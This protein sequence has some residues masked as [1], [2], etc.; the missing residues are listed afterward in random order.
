MTDRKKQFSDEPAAAP[1]LSEN[2]YWEVITRRDPA[3]DGRFWYGVRT[4]GVYCRPSCASRQ[5]K[6]EN[7]EFFALP[8]AARQRGYRPCRRCRP[9]AVA[10]RDPQSE[11]VQRICRL[12]DAN[13]AENPDLA[14]LGRQVQVSPSHLQRVFK[15]L[16]GISPR[17][18]L[19]ARR[20]DRFKAGVKQ[21]RSVTEAMYDAGYGSSSRLYEKAAGQ[22]GM[23]PATYR[24]GGKGMNIGY[25]IA[26][27][28][29]GWLLVAATARGVCW[30]KLGDDREQLA[31]RLRDEFPRAEI[32]RD[33][34]HLHLQ[35]Q[36][37]LECLAGQ[38]PHT[39]LPL[40]VQGTAFQMRVWE[41]LRRIPRGQTV[42]Y[43]ELAAR[44]GRP[45][46]YRAVANACAG[47]PVSVLTPCHR[48]VR[49]DGGLGG[50]ACGVERK[51]V[52]LEKEREG[53]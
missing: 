7:V 45:R 53:K 22:L 8:D 13:V 14:F 5:P 6:R 29:L 24:K 49:E 28:P 36:V 10:A 48:V 39:D 46:A 38:A 21:G 2:E 33:D 11:L 26:E 34:E 32:R 18:Y 40:D 30:V 52:L 35:V 19:A 27:S 9:D 50:Y 17:R 44:I 41:E 51:R 20:A 37:L 23:T 25:A 47:N 1:M 4:T 43:K 16:L 3:F 42:T 15:K 12:L 31:D